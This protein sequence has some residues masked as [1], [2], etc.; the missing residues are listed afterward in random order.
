M[1][2][3]VLLIVFGILSALVALALVAGGILLISIVGS[4]GWIRSGDNRVQTATYA[5]LSQPHELAEEG[6]DVNFFGDRE[7][8]LSAESRD[9]DEEIFIGVGPTD[10]VEEFLD[11]VDV[12]VVVDVDY[13]PLTFDTQ[14]VDGSHRPRLPERQEF[15]TDSIAGPGKQTL[16]FDLPDGSFRVVMMNASG[17]QG[18][19]VDASLGVRAPFVKEAG[20]IMVV[21]G[22]FFLLV[23]IFLLIFAARTRVE[24]SPPL[25][26][27]QPVPPAPPAA[28]EAAASGGQEVPPPP[29]AP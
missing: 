13:P 21:V 10:A 14:R 11:G 8:E 12:D 4:D 7:L 2:R 25:P 1:V 22:G 6:E 24:P 18:V 28:P 19:D 20:I 26:D 17:T 23:G 29:A 9:P 27:S 15:W 3:K 16:D 5:F